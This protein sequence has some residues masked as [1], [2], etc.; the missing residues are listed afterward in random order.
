MGKF[1]LGY[2]KLTVQII[3][4]NTFKALIFINELA[5]TNLILKRLF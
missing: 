5:I 1:D 2:I 3:V 4:K